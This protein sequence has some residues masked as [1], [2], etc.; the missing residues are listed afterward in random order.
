M[1]CCFFMGNTILTADYA[2]IADE[3]KTF[4]HLLHLFFLTSAP[5]AQSAVSK[6]GH[7]PAQIGKQIASGDQPEKL[8]SVH[9][10]GDTST[11]EDPKQV[12]DLRDRRER[13]ES[14]GHRGFHGIV[15]MIR[16]VMHFHQHIGF[17]QDSNR[18][19]VIYDRHLRNIRG[20]HALHSS[21]QGVVRP[22]RNDFARFIAV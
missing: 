8:V 5:S 14:I 13:F 1:S 17:I 20:A 4:A 12:R 19:P 7:L 6:S 10:D 21:E 11:I 3:N 16:I 18:A 15:K 2:D 22:D 9:D